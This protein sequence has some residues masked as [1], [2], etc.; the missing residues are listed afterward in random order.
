MVAQRV[1]S[2]GKRESQWLRQHGDLRTEV[3]AWRRRTEGET[4]WTVAIVIAIGIALQTAVPGRLLLLR[5]VWLAPAVQGAFLVALVIA[6]PHRI[7]RES[8]LLRALSLV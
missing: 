4:R 7:N 2:E 8:R 1:E 5:P 6:N 3:P